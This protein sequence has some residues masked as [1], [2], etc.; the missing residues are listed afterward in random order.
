MF[1]GDD[2]YLAPLWFDTFSNE[3]RSLSRGEKYLSIKPS[4][5]Y[6]GPL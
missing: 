5:P 2:E 3:Q 1:A 4:L 6:L